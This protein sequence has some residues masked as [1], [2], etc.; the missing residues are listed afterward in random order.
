MRYER[1]E[2]VASRDN[3]FIASGP[4][5]QSPKL[6]IPS[7]FISGGPML[8]GKLRGKPVDLISVF[9]GVGAHAAGKIDDDELLA[10]ENALAVAEIA[11]LPDGNN[12]LSA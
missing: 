8:A 3:L 11:A 5:K 12:A 9:E 1:K 10:I 7:I 2:H 4:R 6:D